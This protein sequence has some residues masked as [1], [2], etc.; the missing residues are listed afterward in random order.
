MGWRKLTSWER[1]FDRTDWRLLCTRLNK[2]EFDFN[3]RAQHVRI[4]TGLEKE[5][6]D[7]CD[8]AVARCSVNFHKIFPPRILLQRKK[9]VFQLRGIIKI[10]KSVQIFKLPIKLS[11]V[12]LTR[13]NWEID[14]SSAMMKTQPKGFRAIYWMRWIIKG[15]LGT[16]LVELR[17]VKA[18][19]IVKLMSCTNYSVMIS[20]MAMLTK[21]ICVEC[22]IVTSSRDSS[23]KHENRHLSVNTLYNFSRDVSSLVFDS[24]FTDAHHCDSIFPSLKFYKIQKLSPGRHKSRAYSSLEFPSSQSFVWR[25]FMQIYD[26]SFHASC[27]SCLL[28]HAVS[29]KRVHGE[30]KCWNHYSQCLHARVDKSDF[31]HYL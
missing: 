27:E 2:S 28:L 23:A 7:G 22:S 21:S 26:D 12:K 25:V 19:W 15:A 5:W 3:D 24:L 31:P 30:Y 20:E 18:H 6:H 9:K 4:M 16:S 13:I 17:C 29:S 14:K 10:H 1:S 11:A 8:W